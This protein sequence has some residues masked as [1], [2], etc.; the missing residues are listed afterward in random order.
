MSIDFSL[1]P[2]DKILLGN[3]ACLAIARE[4]A[5][6]NED[7]PEITEG[8]LAEN[9][10]CFVTL[11]SDGNLRGCIGSI[12]GVE[13]LCKNVMRMAKAAAFE[14]HRFQKLTEEEWENVQMEISVLGPITPCPDINSIELGKHGLLLAYGEHRGVFLPKVPVEQGWDLTAYLENLSRKAGLPRDAWKSEQAKIFWYEALVFD[15]N[16]KGI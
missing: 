16:R 4:L 3:I 1:S 13:P 6:S 12:V 15:V 9:L 2:K 10:G 11:Y 7:I 8:I 5:N 14:D